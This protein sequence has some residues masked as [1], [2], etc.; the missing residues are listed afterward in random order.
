MTKRMFLMIAGVC[1]MAAGCA[2]HVDQPLR[3]MTYNVHHTA[4]NDGVV[5]PEE[6][7][8]VIREQ[9][10]DLVAIQEMDLQTKRV[11]GRNLPK[12]LGERTGLHAM[13]GAAMDF[14]DGKYGQLILSKYPIKSSRV[15]PLPGRADAEPRIAFAAEIALANGRRLRL[16]TTHLD[17]VGKETDR[18]LQSAELVRLFGSGEPTTILAGDFN[19]K[20]ESQTITNLKATFTNTSGEDLAPT[21]PAESPNRKIDWIFIRPNES[22][23]VLKT[24]VVEETHASDHRPVVVDLVLQAKQ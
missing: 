19:A 13:F 15:Y 2:H 12:E 6:I 22:W 20:P 8:K 17:H 1:L 21:F 24:S 14:Q 4:N 23:Q 16:V 18:L 11:S 10:P 9:K 3:V 5:A 7:A